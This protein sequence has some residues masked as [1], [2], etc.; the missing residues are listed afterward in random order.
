MDGKLLSA[1]GKV[2]G[3]AGVALGVFF[4]LF[5]QVIEQQVTSHA[6]LNASQAFAIIMSFMILT[7]GI[8][9][10]GFFAWLVA[11]T[12]PDA[13]PVPTSTLALLSALLTLVIIVAAFVGNA[14]PDPVPVPPIVPGPTPTPVPPAPAPTPRPQPVAKK[15]CFGNGR[16]GDDCTGGAYAVLNCGTY[17]NV[18]AGIR[19]FV[20]NEYCPNQPSSLE[21]VINHG[22]GECGW[23]GFIVTC[24]P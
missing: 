10:L 9:A 22:G 14:R 23:T 17:R 21:M 19:D 3:L 2:A 5:R 1:V 12:A 24:N 18:G 4:L 15:I 8:A 13:P 6:Q 7:F 11:P 20:K 16:N